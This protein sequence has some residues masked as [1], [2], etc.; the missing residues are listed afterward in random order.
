MHLPPAILV[1]SPVK[2]PVESPVESPADSEKEKLNKLI[3]FLDY[4]QVSC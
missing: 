4:K 1:E 3:S 2:S